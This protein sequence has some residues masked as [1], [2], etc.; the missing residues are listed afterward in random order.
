M[1]N[2]LLM[3]ALAIVCCIFSGVFAS[4]QVIQNPS[5]ETVSAALTD[6]NTSAGL[7]NSGPIPAWTQTGT[8][9]QLLPGS[10]L[11]S[12]VPNGIM[13]A[14]IND[15]GSLSQDLGGPTPNSVYTLGV[16]VGRRLDIAAGSY[17]ISLKAGTATLCTTTGSGSSIAAGQ[18]VAVSLTCPA[19]TAPN[20]N[21]VV[22]LSTSG[23]GVQTNFD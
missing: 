16:Y 5:F 1:K 2:K 20:G 12:S 11:F 6:T 13:T 9:G 4:A 22:T 15:A 18:F 23:S 21:L 7:Y 8:V 3:A 17:T 14:Y 10:A 19:G